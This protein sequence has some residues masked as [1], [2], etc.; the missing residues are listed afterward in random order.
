MGEAVVYWY[1]D[2]VATRGC[3]SALHN[4]GEAGLIISKRAEDIQGAIHFSSKQD[5]EFLLSRTLVQNSKQKRVTTDDAELRNA[6]AILVT[7]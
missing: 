5:F 1:R 6:R 7:I 2:R 3:R 4:H